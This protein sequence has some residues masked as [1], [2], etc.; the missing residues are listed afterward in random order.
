MA[1]QLRRGLLYPRGKQQWVFKAGVHQQKEA[2]NGQI[3]LPTL[4]GT[5]QL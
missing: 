5:E 1:Q 2:A 3:S 4:V